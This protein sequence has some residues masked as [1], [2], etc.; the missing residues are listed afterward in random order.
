MQ[1]VQLL[2]DRLLDVV[3][4]H[5]SVRLGMLS[6]RANLA[7]LLLT[8]CNRLVVLPAIPAT[9]Y[10]D[11]VLNEILS[12]WALL[13]GLG[14]LGDGVNRGFRVHEPCRRQRGD[15]RLLCV[16]SSA[17]LKMFFDLKCRSWGIG[18]IVS[19]GRVPARL[20]HSRMH[21]LLLSRRIVRAHG[22]RRLSLLGKLHLG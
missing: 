17:E 13:L 2:L 11:S 8:G 3:H 21:M 6:S 16:Q 5:A 4:H 12:S 1:A 7:D 20:R 9:A 18:A 10:L 15:L 14:P 19:P 22:R